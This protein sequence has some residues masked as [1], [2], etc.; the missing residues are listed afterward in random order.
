MGMGLSISRS[1]V[2]T[3]GGRSGPR[4]PPARRGEP[5]RRQSEKRGPNTERHCPSLVRE[6]P[7]TSSEAGRR[8]GVV[9]P[10]VSRGSSGGIGCRRNPDSPHNPKVA[11][12]NPAP[13]TMNGEGLA[14]VE[15]ASPFRLP[16][17]HPGIGWPAWSLG[18]H[19][20]G[21]RCMVKLRFPRNGAGPK[22][23]YSGAWPGHYQLASGVN[24]TRFLGRRWTTMTAAQEAGH[25]RQST[26]VYDSWR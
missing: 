17:L 12:S 4:K 15:A 3:H 13:A 23:K 6:R 19:V 11:G 16:R 2:I 1:V 9:L 20:A 25:A 7:R 5:A 24:R 18:T 21:R 22:A 26:E 14:D 10:V 8:L